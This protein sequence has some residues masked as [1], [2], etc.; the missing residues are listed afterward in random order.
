MT[1]IDYIL[2]VAQSISIHQIWQKQ[3]SKDFFFFISNISILKMGK[4]GT[5]VLLIFMSMSNKHKW[6]G[7]DSGYCRL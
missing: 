4:K 3:I 1:H 7:G 5:F 6:I 2:T